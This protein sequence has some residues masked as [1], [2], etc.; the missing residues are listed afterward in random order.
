MKVL[1]EFTLISDC[2]L[3]FDAWR[4]VGVRTRRSRR[5]LCGRECRR[6]THSA[7]SHERLVH[8]WQPR[9]TSLRHSDAA[10]RLDCDQRRRGTGHRACCTLLPLG[11]L[12]STRR[13]LHQ[14]LRT[15]GGQ[16]GHSARYATSAAFIVMYEKCIQVRV[17]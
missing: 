17:Y 5:E 4:F 8:E 16:F 9:R 15:L 3:V 10:P 7:E 11:R 1:T 14:L 2:K 6:A 13:L 12:S